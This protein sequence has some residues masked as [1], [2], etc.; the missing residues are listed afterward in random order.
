MLNYNH[1]LTKINVLGQKKN[2]WLLRHRRVCVFIAALI[3]FTL[4]KN[5]VSVSDHFRN[6]F[7]SAPVRSVSLLIVIIVSKAF[8]SKACMVVS[9]ISCHCIL[10]NTDYYNNKKRCLPSFLIKIFGNWP[11]KLII[12]FVWP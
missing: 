7:G 9:G 5:V 10:T 12:V 11:E 1:S 2:C 8:M 3:V 4:G 6:F